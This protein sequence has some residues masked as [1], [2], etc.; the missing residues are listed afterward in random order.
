MLLSEAIRRY[1]SSH[2]VRTH[3]VGLT[4]R[5]ASACWSSHSEY[6][7]LTW[8]LWFQRLRPRRLVDVICDVHDIKSQKNVSLTCR[9]VAAK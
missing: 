5:N 2:T 3:T 8:L 9:V 7:S 4:Y 1:A 6:E